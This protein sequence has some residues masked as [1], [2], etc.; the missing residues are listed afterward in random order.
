MKKRAQSET[1]WQ[2][3]QF[4]TLMLA[5]LAVIPFELLSFFSVHVP[6][7]LEVPILLA[8]I[9]W[10]GRD[11]LKSGLQSLSRFDFSDINLLMTIAVSGALYLRQLPEAALIV[12]L[13]ALGEAMEHYG[14]EKSRAALETLV[15]NSP[16]TALVKGEENKRPIEEV[17]IGH[18]VIVK[19]GDL[20]PLDGE[21]VEGHSLIDEASITGEP[22]P[23]SKNVGDAVYAGTLNKDGYLEIKVTKEAKDTTLAKIISLTYESA[24]KK[25]RSQQF[26]DRFSSYYTPSIVV[27]AFLTVVIPV[28]VLGKPFD[29]WFVQALT[30]LIIGCPC[31][32]VISTPVAVFSAL[33]NATK[34]GALIKGGRFIEAMGTIKAIALDKTR[35]LTKGEPVV[36]DIVPLNGTTEEEVLACAAGIE[37]FSEH[38]LAQS[39]LKRAKEMGVVAS[40]FKNF[41]SV[42]GKGIRGECLVCHDSHHCLGSLK[43]IS[44]EGHKVSEEVVK[45]VKKFE[46][47]GKTAIV[48]SSDKEVKGVIAITD[49]IRLESKEVIRELSKLG[50][51]TAIFTGDNL[52]A[53]LYVARN[54]GIKEV[55]AALLPDGKVT[56]LKKLQEK[57]GQLAMV[58]DGVN[59]APALATAS[60]GIAMGAVG[61]DVAIENA[62]IALM[63]NDLTLLPYLVRIG[64]KAQEKIRFNISAAVLTKLF[65]L[66]LALMG[67]SNLALAIFADVGVT[68]LV[69][70]NSLRLYSYE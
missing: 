38:P 69:I 16:K 14:V 59:D 57:Y 43:F 10:F 36:S 44:E 35:T 18:I 66:V 8:A 6:F 30:I 11:V 24:E 23:K 13:F 4:M 20:I 26:I 15:E 61:S 22:L 34:R 31:A 63:G 37:G 67:S 25:S 2:N 39:I 40:R 65:F 42:M 53:A 68:V 1:I 3:R 47:E 33:G 60:V 64:R 17:A 55:K 28:F 49:E 19:P 12:V 48:M 32:L 45:I 70:L 51:E 56:E 9:F 46:S 52:P 27:V 54:L 41:Q 7:W 50:I 29:P 62:D 5:I 58:G 21:V